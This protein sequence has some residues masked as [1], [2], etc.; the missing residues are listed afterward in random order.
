ML[1]VWDMW[2]EVAHPRLFPADPMPL[3]YQLEMQLR[4]AFEAG[5]F[6]PDGRVPG[7]LELTD[8]YGVSRITVRKALERLEEDGL[9]VRRRGRGTFVNKERVDS[10]RV[11]R[12]PGSFLQFEDELRRAGIHPRVELK[13]CE[14][15]V[16]PAPVLASLG[17][18]PETTLWRVRRIGFDHRAPLWLE[19]RYY[20]LHLREILTEDRLTEISINP[21]LTRH[22]FPITGEQWQLEAVL[23]TPRQAK[24]LG[25]ARTV[26]VFRSIFTSFSGE[27]PV[28]FA[29]VVFRGDRYRVA[30][31][32]GSATDSNRGEGP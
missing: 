32:F 9:L 26:P 4:R 27:S 24:L 15:G 1:C 2:T 8:L 19:T 11:S 28:Q 20:P 10:R 30:L 29:E 3:Y 14:T 13:G 18:S 31:T 6:D 22:G 12:N 7:E 16:G 5:Q 23:P 25:A 21:V 17:L